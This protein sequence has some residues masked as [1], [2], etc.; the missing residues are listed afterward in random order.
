MVNKRFVGKS[1]GHGKK[2]YGSSGVIYL[3]FLGPKNKFCLLIVDF[4]VISA[5]K[6]FKGYS[7]VHKMT[8]L[9]IYIYIYR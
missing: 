5:G 7:E 8:K 3:L 9:E 6:T 2:V 4:A 1:L